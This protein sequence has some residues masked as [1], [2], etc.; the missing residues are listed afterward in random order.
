MLRN[1]WAIISAAIN[2]CR[3]QSSPPGEIRTSFLRFSCSMFWNWLNY[4]EALLG[5]VREC[6]GCHDSCSRI[7]AGRLP[8]VSRSLFTTPMW[9]GMAQLN[10][11]RCCWRFRAIAT[12]AYRR[13][14]QH[15]ERNPVLG[16]Q[17]ALD[18]ST[19]GVD[20][21][22]PYRDNPAFD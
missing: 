16:L 14:V 8:A 3:G 20:G 18:G 10:A 4:H 22:P 17:P 19:V 15:R 21:A 7:A 6:R 13:G 9:S 2:P 5:L 1:S 11:K 12:S